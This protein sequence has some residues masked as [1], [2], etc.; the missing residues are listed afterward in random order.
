MPT[1]PS[2]S[3][4]QTLVFGFAGIAVVA[5][6]LAVLLAS[7]DKATAESS[8]LLT[9]TIPTD[10]DELVRRAEV[11]FQEGD[12]EESIFWYG[13]ANHTEPTNTTVAFEYVRVLTF[14]HYAETHSSYYLDEALE[15]AENTIAL[16][17]ADAF[18]QA[19]F[20]RVLIELDRTDEALVAALSAVELAPDWAEAHA[21]LAMAYYTDGRF[22][23]ALETAQNAL[24]LDPNSMDA[25]RAMALSLAFTGDFEGAIEEYLAVITLYPYLDLLY[26][27]L[28]P[29]YVIQEDFAAAQALYDVVLEHNPRNAKAWT[30]KCETY[31]RK[32]DD[33]AAFD[34]CS[35]ALELDDTNA[36]VYQL[37][38]M[39]QYTRRDYEGSVESFNQ[40]IGLMDEQAWTDDQRHVECYYLQGLAEDFLDHCDNALGLFETALSINAQEYVT[41]SIDG[42]I[43]ICV[44]A[45]SDEILEGTMF[46]D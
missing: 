13:L 6:M 39:M 33:S 32:R 18:A 12:I 36:D 16:V 7:S 23:I 45:H 19:A 4:T 29:Y 31:F 15:I 20:A 3:K 37:M 24:D 11:E 44:A 35:N 41:N 42:G 34:A 28:A 1:N 8:L 14:Q 2:V 26:F 40:C 43:A 22:N 10:V 17:P 9:A 46:E 30:R 38:G 25:H 5:M 27:E 21:L